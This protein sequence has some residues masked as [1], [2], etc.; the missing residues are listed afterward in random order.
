MSMTPEEKKARK[1]EANRRYREA[2]KEKEVERN[3]RYSEAN[4]E[5][6]A[7]RKRRYC[8]A[9]KKKM[10]EYQRR[11]EEANKEKKTHRNRCRKRQIA[12]LKEDGSS[13]ESWLFSLIRPTAAFETIANLQPDLGQTL[14]ELIHEL[15]GYAMDV[16]EQ[17]ANPPVIEDA[18]PAKSIPQPDLF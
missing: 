15:S 13:F 7:E 11:Y 9:N 14:A 8:E 2:N 6:E 4:K 12:F 3:R 10:A 16:C 1:A 17:I 18:P 5:K